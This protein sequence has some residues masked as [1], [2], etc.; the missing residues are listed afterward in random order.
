[1]TLEK[2]AEH[3]NMNWRHWQ[4]VEAGEVNATL[5]TLARLAN[6]LDVDPSELLAMPARGRTPDARYSRRRLGTS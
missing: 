4:K 2:A 6:A 3:G 5:R 1:M